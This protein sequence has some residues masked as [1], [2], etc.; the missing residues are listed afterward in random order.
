MNRHVHTNKWYKDQAKE[1]EERERAKK[2]IPCLLCTKKHRTD[3]Q[4]SDYARQ[5]CF[6]YEDEKIDFFKAY[7]FYGKSSDEFF[8]K[9]D[10]CCCTNQTNLMDLNSFIEVFEKARHDQSE[11]VS[12]R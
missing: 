2:G 7:W 1:E 10:Y 6:L 8:A 9:N 12:Q 3:K 5:F 4:I 11:Q